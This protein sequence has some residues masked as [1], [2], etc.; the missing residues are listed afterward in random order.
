MDG[1]VHKAAKV[2]DTYAN[3]L[4]IKQILNFNLGTIPSFILSSSSYILW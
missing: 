2:S 1:W 3:K 4:V